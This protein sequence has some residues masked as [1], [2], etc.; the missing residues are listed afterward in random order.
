MEYHSISEKIRILVSRA[1]V[2]ALVVI[3]LISESYWGKHELIDTTL[4]AIGCFCASIAALG[5]LWCALYIAGY[6]NNTL[7]MTGPYS[8]S[9]NPLYF[10]SLIGAVGVGLA[11]ETFLI[12]IIISIAFLFYYPGVIRGEEKRLAAAH[13]EAYEAYR[14]RVPSFFPKF[15]LFEEPDTY[16]VNPKVFRRNMS[17][18]LW[19]VWLVAILEIIEALHETGTLR[20]HFQIY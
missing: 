14:K 15:S 10:F 11:T 3:L 1:F 20:V 7:I 2:V 17:S 4:F 8:I 9:R 13:G 12:P 18:A 16:V 5:R 19:F 6:K